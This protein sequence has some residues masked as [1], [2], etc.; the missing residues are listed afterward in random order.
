MYA[1]LNSPEWLLPD[2]TSED[3]QLWM[4]AVSCLRA[5]GVV[6]VQRGSS[7]QVPGATMTACYKNPGRWLGRRRMPT[8]VDS[9]PCPGSQTLWKLVPQLQ[10]Q[11]IWTRLFCSDR[12]EKATFNMLKPLPH[13][14]CG[15]PDSEKLDIQNKIF[16][17]CTERSVKYLYE[18]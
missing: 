5:P 11:N 14:L 10:L 18:I 15:G 8:H 1:H 4:R 9:E 17:I 7:Q 6:D 13:N 2:A 3:K 16:H 12:N